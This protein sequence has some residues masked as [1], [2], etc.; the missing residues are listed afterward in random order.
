MK[1]TTNEKV[2]A[3]VLKNSPYKENDMIVHL[4]TLQYGKMSVIA[5]GVR[6]ITSKSAPGC[7]SMTKSSMDI[8]L[9]KGLSTLIRAEGINYYRRIK[10]NIESEIIANVILEYY[11][12]YVEENNPSVEEYDMLNASL[13][14]LNN[15]YSP[16]TIYIL[17]LIYVLKHEGIELEVDGCV[18]CQDTK[19]VSISYDGGF[20]C[21]NHLGN[22]PVLD[23]EVLKAFRH[24]HKLSIHDIDKLQYKEKYLKQILPILEYYLDEFTGIQ[25]KSKVFINSLFK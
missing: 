21:A 19:V 5:R 7:S 2:E 1:T 12:R 18:V 15:G 6:K 16:L 14:A 24:F 4:Y 9:K 17:F 23:K 22:L 20:V 8:V 3:I 13:E 11:Y 10:E 25:F